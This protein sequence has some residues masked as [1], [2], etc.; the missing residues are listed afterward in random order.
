MSYLD[1]KDGPVVIEVPAGVQGL[2][3]DI[4]VNKDGSIEDHVDAINSSRV[5]TQQARNLSSGL[6]HCVAGAEFA[7][8]T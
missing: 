6:F 4:A 2:L 1:L 7:T 8:R 5:R 3:D